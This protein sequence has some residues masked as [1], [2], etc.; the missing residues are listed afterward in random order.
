MPYAYADDCALYYERR[1]EQHLHSTPVLLIAGYGANLA[2]WSPL[3][4]DSLSQRHRLIL[5]DN[6]G[7]GNSGKPPGPYTMGQF[8]DDAATVLDAAGIETAHVL[9][10]SMG[11]MIAQNFALRHAERVRGLILGC[12]LP[13]GPQSPDVTPPSEAVMRVLLAPRTDDAAQDIRNLWPI[14][15]SDEFVEHHRDLLEEW[16]RVKS[17]YPQAPQHALESQMHAVTETHNVLDRLHEIR[18]PTLVLT[19]SADVLI[20]PQNSRLIAGRIPNAELIEY[21]GVGHDFVE[22]AGRRVVDD[23]LR[24]LAQVEAQP[25]RS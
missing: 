12:T 8:A 1:G 17:A 19:G 24:F 16:L 10:V 3:L 6:R 22:E 5:F 2:G 14:L 25:E 13:C 4:V 18:Q 7:A 9:G 20:P 21:E 15:Y 23:I 11:G